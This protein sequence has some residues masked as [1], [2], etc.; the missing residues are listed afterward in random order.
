MSLR[1]SRCGCR[2][3]HREA[4]I[5]L[6]VVRLS[7]SRLDLRQFSR[8]RWLP[9][10]VEV[11]C[12][13]EKSTAQESA[14]PIMEVFDRGPRSSGPSKSGAGVRRNCSAHPCPP[15][16]RSREK[17][18]PWSRLR[19]RTTEQCAW[20]PPPCR[21]ER[22]R[23]RTARDRRT[24]GLSVRRPRR[25]AHAL[26]ADGTRWL[27]FAGR[28]IASRTSGK[29]GGRRPR[30]CKRSRS[31][32][33]LHQ[34]FMARMLNEA[35]RRA[36]PPGRLDASCRG[37]SG[38]RRRCSSTP[39]PPRRSMNAGSQESRPLPP[40]TGRPASSVSTELSTPGTNPLNDGVTSK[41]SSTS[42][43]FGPAR[44]EVY[45]APAPI[46]NR[47]CPR[48]EDALAGPGLLLQARRLRPTRSRA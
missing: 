37:E 14:D 13:S 21:D 40:L 42:R 5:T 36:R 47:G 1:P 9:D 28:G 35:L 18:F 26:D 32:Q 46:P 11:P 2:R 44:T 24:S 43:A 17:G 30:L 29:P 6:N 19:C 12:W 22:D 34:G 16:T 15:L 31:D 7:N 20:F 38:R 48:V 27:D 33:Y 25:W 41:P 45:R 8:V 10:G 23:L 39:A 3:I 4:P